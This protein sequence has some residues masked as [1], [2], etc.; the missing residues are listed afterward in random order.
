[1]F[2]SRRAACEICLVFFSLLYVCA[3]IRFHPDQHGSSLPV[4]G[5]R[6]GVGACNVSGVPLLLWKAYC[7]YLFR[8]GGGTVTARFLRALIEGNA[9]IA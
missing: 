5:F 7:N 6:L 4:S 9:D 8:V 2:F 3:R 1:M